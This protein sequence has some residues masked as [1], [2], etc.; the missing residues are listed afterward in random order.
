[1]L[2]RHVL[3][4]SASIPSE[5][6]G[7]GL[8]LRLLSEAWSTIQKVYVDRD[9]VAS[10]KL[11]YGAIAGMVESLGDTGH[12]T[13]MTPDMMEEQ[14]TLTQGAFEGV[15][16]EVQMKDGHVVIVSPLDDSPALKAGIRPGDVILKETTRASMART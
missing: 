13:F 7:A 9:A 10:Q 11:T 1:M 4:A 2:D 12:S 15:G 5:T 6:P 3:T 16:A 14:Q 8:D